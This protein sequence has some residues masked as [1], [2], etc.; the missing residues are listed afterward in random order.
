M[1]AYI[2]GATFVLQQLYGLSA[3]QFSFA[4]GANALGIMVLGQLVVAGVTL[5]LTGAVPL[6][7]LVRPLLSAPARPE[8]LA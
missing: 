6:T 8:T 3:Q 1:F 7:G 5:G 4:F 2:S